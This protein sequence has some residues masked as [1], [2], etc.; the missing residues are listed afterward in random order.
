MPGPDTPVQETLTPGGSPGPGAGFG[1]GKVAGSPVL[2]DAQDS[3]LHRYLHELIDAVLEYPNDLIAEGIEGTVE[4]ALRFSSD[5]RL[6]MKGSPV[7]SDSRFLRLLVIRALRKAFASPL[8]ASHRPRASAFPVK[9]TFLFRIT[10]E[11][12]KGR[13]TSRA[14]HSV[15]YLSFLREQHIK[16]PLRL[17]R[18][19]F[20]EDSGQ[21][22]PVLSFDLLWLADKIIGNDGRK[23]DRLQKYRDDPDF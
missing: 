18:P 11:D 22:S 3:A 15:G 13:F 20:A 16:L 17:E 12:P 5:G 19:L 7:T 6:L 21:A 23:I 14:S 2:S 1:I 4:A 10:R 8:A 9:A